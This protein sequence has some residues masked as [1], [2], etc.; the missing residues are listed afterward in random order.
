M[1]RPTTISAPFDKATI[2]GNRGKQ[3]YEQL[4]RNLG[5]INVYGNCI[6]SYFDS[7]SYFGVEGKVYFHFARGINKYGL[8]LQ[9]SSR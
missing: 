2:A 8:V 9:C 1:R 4:N 5:D 3:S 6:I 7:E